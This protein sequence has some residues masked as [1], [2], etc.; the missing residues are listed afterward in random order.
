[1]IAEE[2]LH[3]RFMHNNSMGILTA[4]ENKQTNNPD[5]SGLSKECV[6]NEKNRMSEWRNKRIYE[7]NTKRNVREEEPS[8]EFLRNK[9]NV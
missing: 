5:S 1:L 9:K 4:A 8:K 2:N 6:R 7:R 3:E